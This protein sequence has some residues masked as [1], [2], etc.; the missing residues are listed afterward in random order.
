MHLDQTLRTLRD[1]AFLESLF[2]G[3]LSILASLISVYYSTHYA[4]VSSSNSVT[5]IILSN[6]RV[7]DV[8]LLFVYGALAAVLF[9]IIVVLVFRL[10]HAPFILKSASLLLLIR[11]VFVSLTHISPYPTH[12]AISDTFLTSTSLAQMF[13]TGDDLF[14]SGHVGLT[15]L[16]ALLLWNT[17]VLRYVYLALSVMFAVVVLLGHIHYSIDVFAAYFITYTIYSMATHVFKDD[18]RRTLEPE[19]SGAV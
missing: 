18:Y 1:R 8:D 4:T 11:S 12:A 14:F 2:L 19:P 5:D 6:T 17:P 9:S 16:M 7:Y 3:V 10:R 15:F 13:F